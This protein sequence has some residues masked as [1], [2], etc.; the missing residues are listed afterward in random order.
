LPKS[1]LGEVDFHFRGVVE[2][3]GEDVE[4]NVRDDLGDLTIGEARAPHIFYVR[5]CGAALFCN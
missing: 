3:V 5:V 1:D 2:V 4:R